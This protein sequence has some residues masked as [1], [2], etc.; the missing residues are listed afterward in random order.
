MD[1]TVTTIVVGTTPESRVVRH[2]RVE[3]NFRMNKNR[4]DCRVHPLFRSIDSP[5]HW[6]GRM[7]QGS[8]HNSSWSLRSSDQNLCKI[9]LENWFRSGRP[10]LLDTGKSQFPVLSIE[11]RPW[12]SHTPRFVDSDQSPTLDWVYHPSRASPP[13]EFFISVGSLPPS[14]LSYLP[15]GSLT[16]V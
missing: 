6:K 3:W 2:R 5:V 9:P 13:S 10:M 11:T 15:I 7:W 16:L 12:P 4:N 1:S 8:L 14:W